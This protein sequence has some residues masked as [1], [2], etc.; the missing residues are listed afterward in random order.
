MLLE[1]RISELVAQADALRT[2]AE[3]PELTAIVDE[4]N[5]LR[6]MQCRG[7]EIEPPEPDKPRR[8][9]PPKAKT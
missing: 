6:D 2:V 9:R 5:R 4:I 1:T 7:E 8:G 3:S